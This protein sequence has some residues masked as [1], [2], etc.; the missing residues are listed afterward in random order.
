MRAFRLSPPVATS[1]WDRAELA[2]DAATPF[3]GLAAVAVARPD[4]LGWLG[5][6]GWLV[7]VLDFFLGT[8]FSRATTT[9]QRVRRLAGPAVVLAGQ[10]FE[11]SPGWVEWAI[12]SAICGMGARGAALL[13]FFAREIGRQRTWD[14]AG[15]ALPG[16]VAVAGFSA[17]TVM[18]FSDAW[19]ALH[20]GPSDVVQLLAGFVAAGWA[21]FGRL[22]RLPAAH[23]LLSDDETAVWIVVLLALWLVA[24]GGFYAWMR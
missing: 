15:V 17:A 5:A 9:A 12:E 23:P 22:G 4:W 11:G 24:A 7:L 13:G 1:R 19:L 20:P 6:T 14:D 8:H 18:A 16:V 2:I 21:D 3:L 10:A